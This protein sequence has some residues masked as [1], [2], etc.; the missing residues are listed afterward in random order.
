MLELG[1]LGAQ[2]AGH[3]ELGDSKFGRGSL[4]WQ[5]CRE[6]VASTLD[7]LGAVQVGLALAEIKVT[8]AGTRCIRFGD[9]TILARDVQPTRD[10]VT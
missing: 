8:W 5:C 6:W 4:L 10:L 7:D 2:V 3:L 1:N 9:L